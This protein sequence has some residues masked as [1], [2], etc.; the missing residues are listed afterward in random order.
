MDRKLLT[1]SWLSSERLEV[2]IE[3]PLAW[4]LGD[5]FEECERMFKLG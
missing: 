1:A 2:Y 5:W 3:V 4:M